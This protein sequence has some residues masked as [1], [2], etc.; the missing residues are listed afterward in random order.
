MEEFAQS[1]DD[2]D[3]FDDEIT[4]L[5]PS[6]STSHVG[7]STEQLA[8]QAETTALEPATTGPAKHHPP[9]EQLPPAAT[10]PAVSDTPNTS[11][12]TDNDNATIAPAGPSKPRPAPPSLDRHLTGG[13]LPKPKLSEA[14]LSAKLASAKLKADLPGVGAGPKSREPKSQAQA[15]AVNSGRASA[16]WAEQVEMEGAW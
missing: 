12:P 1:R 15:S 8:Q 3:L 13:P 14:E 5:E 10:T 4:P 11:T 7:D 6:Q 2:D 16:N 9:S